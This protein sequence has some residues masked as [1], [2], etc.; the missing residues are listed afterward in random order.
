MAMPA[1]AKAR[2]EIEQR[3][4]GHLVRMCREPSEVVRTGQIRCE[5]RSQERCDG[6]NDENHA[7]DDRNLSS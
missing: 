4:S 2:D 5:R 3:S 7:C 1:L 6:R